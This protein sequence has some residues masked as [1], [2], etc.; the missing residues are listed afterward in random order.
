MLTDHQQDLLDASAGPVQFRWGLCPV[1]RKPLV[2]RR[3]KTM[4]FKPCS[5]HPEAEPRITDVCRLCKRDTIETCG[6]TVLD[7]VIVC[8][9]CA[10]E[11]RASIFNA[12]YQSWMYEIE[13]KGE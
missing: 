3:A 13:G 12:G 10:S 9:P 11:H 5:E 7:G 6:R 1:C 8:K 2:K 4:L